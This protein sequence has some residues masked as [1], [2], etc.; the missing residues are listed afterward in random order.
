MVAGCLLLAAS[1]AR[2]VESGSGVSRPS[3]PE[4]EVRDAIQHLYGGQY[5]QVIRLTTGSR[6]RAGGQELLAQI[7]RSA[8]GAASTSLVRILAPPDLRNTAI[9][10][11]GELGSDHEAFVYLPS[12]S[13]TKRVVGS[14][15]D[16]ERLFG[17]SL[18]LSDLS[19]PFSGEYRVLEASG[20]EQQCS[21]LNWIRPA[22]NSR[23]GYDRILTC[24]QEQKAVFAWLEFYRDGEAVRRLAVDES[25]VRRIGDRLVATEMKLFDGSL[26]TSV[27][28]EFSAELG[29]LP[30]SL[31]SVANLARGSS[32]RDRSIA[33]TVAR[34][35]YGQ[36]RKPL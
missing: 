24:L 32:Q 17:T 7:I 28:I 2:P 21:Q 33:L 19:E 20:S 9:L 3:R 22:S 27:H 30:D 18:V 11:R 8:H 12:I 35:T 4:D 26:T 15:L 5:F 10:L 34:D 31:F 25:H 36:L 16:R 14:S 23:Q 1:G 13:A 29:D 6:G